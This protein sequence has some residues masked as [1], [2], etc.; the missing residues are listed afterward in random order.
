LIH[1]HSGAVKSIADATHTRAAAG[2]D[3]ARLAINKAPISCFVLVDVIRDVMKD[4][5]CCDC[6]VLDG[7][8]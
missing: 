6:Y 7:L 1:R 2:A 4:S 3:L 5:G 8:L